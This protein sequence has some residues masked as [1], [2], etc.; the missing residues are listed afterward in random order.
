[1]IGIPGVRERIAP[2][3]INLDD[4]DRIEASLRQLVEREGMTVVGSYAEKV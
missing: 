4:A 3:A 2:D 1:M